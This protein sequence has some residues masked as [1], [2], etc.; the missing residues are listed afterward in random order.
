MCPVQM[1][2]C[3][4][5]EGCPEWMSC[6]GQEGEVSGRQRLMH[7]SSHNPEEQKIKTYVNT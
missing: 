7:C 6:L 2:P 5:D 3:P 4:A 1:Q